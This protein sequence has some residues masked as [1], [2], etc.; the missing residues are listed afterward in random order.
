[1]DKGVTV[2]TRSMY[3]A[4]LPD[5]DGYIHYSAAEHRR[6]AELYSA[7][8]ANVQR[9]AAKEYL[10]GL[11]QLQL[12]PGHIPQCRDVSRVLVDLTGWCVQPVPALIGFAEFFTMLAQRVFPAASFLRTKAD[13][14]YVKEPDI[15]HEIFG[16]TPLLTD[17]RFAA[18]SQS[19]G[20]FGLQ[21]APRDY[22]WLARLYW[23]TIE[24]GLTTEQQQCKPLGAGL[25]SSPS[26]LMY[27]AASD[28]PERRPFHLL[29]VLRTPY[30]IDIHQPVYYVM[31]DLDDLFELA[32]CNLLDKVHQAQ[33]LGLLS[34][35]PA[36]ARNPSQ[37]KEAS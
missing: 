31:A 37:I 12:P 20:K 1:M 25:M 30:R 34:P 32:E 33:V 13:F 9:F 10:H 2:S 7:Q 35:H 17:P 28:T 18:F 4:R 26:E 16:H 3:Q 8:I 11:A 22:A 14:Y 5:R 23:F 24:F 15:F 6:W 21:A 27:A 19:I 36:L 29:D